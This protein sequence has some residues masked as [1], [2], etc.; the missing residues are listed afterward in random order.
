MLAKSQAKI[1]PCAQ[2]LKLKTVE[3][4]RDAEAIANE[5]IEFLYDTHD[6]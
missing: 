5:R 6:H 4:K 1:V 3:V 2:A